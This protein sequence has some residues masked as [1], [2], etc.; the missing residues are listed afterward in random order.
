MGGWVDGWT[1]KRWTDERKGGLANEGLTTDVE[2]EH[3]CSV[4]L[5]YK[6]DK[7]EQIYS[8]VYLS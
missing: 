6:K 7:E 2:Q 3:A 1:D 8:A 5:P 4:N